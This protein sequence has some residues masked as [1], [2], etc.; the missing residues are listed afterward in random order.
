HDLLRADVDRDVLADVAEQLVEPLVHRVGEHQRPGDERHAEDH[1]DGRQHQPDL[2]RREV[3]ERDPAH[4]R[5]APSGPCAP[6]DAAAPDAPAPDAAAGAGSKPFI[7]SS[8]RSAVGSAILSTICP[9][10]RNST[11]SAYAAAVGS[12]VT[13]TIVWPIRRTASR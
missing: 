3:A 11:W 13:I 10:D 7:R 2:V 1:R 8:T 12:C 6:A 9:S 5:A 4:H